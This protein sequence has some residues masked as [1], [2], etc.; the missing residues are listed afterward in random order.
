MNR[1]VLESFSLKSSIKKMYIYYNTQKRNIYIYTYTYKF[2][3]VGYLM[4]EVHI[5]T[6]KNLPRSHFCAL[7]WS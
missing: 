1:N 4:Y 7:T 2:F 6:T 5:D 3:L